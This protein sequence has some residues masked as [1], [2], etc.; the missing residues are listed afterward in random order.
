MKTWIITGGI[1]C[2]KSTL[3]QWLKENVPHVAHF[4]ADVCVRELYEKNRIKEKL[5]RSFGKGIFTAAGGVDRTTLRKTVFDVARKRR[6]LQE[7]LHPA[8]R[9]ACRMQQMEAAANPDVTLFIAEVPLYFETG[10]LYPSDLVVVV[11]VE[12]AQQRERLRSRSN[13]DDAMMDKVLCTQWPI[14]DKVAKAGAVVWNQ[15]SQAGLSR[16]GY[17]L[18]QRW[19]PAEKP[20][21]AQK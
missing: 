3:C 9:S 1:A 13:L 16:Q 18:L 21:S 5:R 4:D 19:L 10:A 2:G 15:G 17:L 11:A 20:A 14:M 8:V 7:I 6:I 12:P